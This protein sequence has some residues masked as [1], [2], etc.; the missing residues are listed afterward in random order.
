MTM[1]QPSTQSP[2]GLEAAVQATEADALLAGSA[3]GNVLRASPEFSSLLEAGE[4]LKLD[5]V[6]DAAI[7]AFGRR[8]EELR[9]PTMLGT[10]EASQ[11]DELDRLQAAMLTCPSVA[12]YL[13]AQAAFQSVCRETAAVVSAQIGIDFAAN[14]RSGGCCG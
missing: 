12:T 9:V 14:R 8:Q 5:A 13:A 6:A 10:L 7:E 2:A 1:I 3:F 11:R 4:R